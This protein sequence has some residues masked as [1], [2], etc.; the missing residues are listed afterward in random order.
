MPEVMGD[1]T[2][3]GMLWQNLIG[4]AIKFRAADRIR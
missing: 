1:A 2:L 3:L 4:N